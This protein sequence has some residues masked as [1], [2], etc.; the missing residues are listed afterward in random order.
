MLKRRR[1]DR[2]QADRVQCTMTIT[3]YAIAYK[4]KKMM[5]MFLKMISVVVR[6]CVMVK[7]VECLWL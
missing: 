5:S 2:V 1:C 7:E 6:L 3:V 4:C